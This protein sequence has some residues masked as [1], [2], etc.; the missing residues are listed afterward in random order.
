MDFGS[1]TGLIAIPVG[2]V[3]TVLTGYITAANDALAGI[4]AWFSGVTGS[5]GG[6]L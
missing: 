5:L 6:S 4:S 2:S 3:D 1:I